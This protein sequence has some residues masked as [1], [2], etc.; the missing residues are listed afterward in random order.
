MRELDDMTGQKEVSQRYRDCTAV[1]EEKQ[2][3]D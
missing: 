3:V 2:E 1:D